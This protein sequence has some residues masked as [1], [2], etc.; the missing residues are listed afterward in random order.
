MERMIY[1]WLFIRKHAEIPDW[2]RIS[3]LQKNI[4]AGLKDLAQPQPQNLGYDNF[5]FKEIE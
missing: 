2:C 4:D 5:L 1:V 3:F